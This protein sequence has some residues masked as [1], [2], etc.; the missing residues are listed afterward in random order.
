MD[1]DVEDEPHPQA[2]RLALSFPPLNAFV[3]HQI[4]KP[5]DSPCPPAIGAPVPAD[6]R[7][8]QAEG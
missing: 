2:I 4:H 1:V 5:R 6:P 7:Y 8:S 3:G